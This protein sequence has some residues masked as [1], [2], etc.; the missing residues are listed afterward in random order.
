MPGKTEVVDTSGPQQ[1]RAGL[2]L[3]FIYHVPLLLLLTYVYMAIHG[4]TS[5]RE[6]SNFDF[7]AGGSPI[8]VVIE[9]LYWSAIGVVAKQAFAL[10]RALTAGRFSFMRGLVEGL[11]NLLSVPVIAVAIVYFL[12]ITKLSISTLDLTL[13]KAD[14]KLI[15]ALSIFLGFFGED[16][17]RFLASIGER[18]MG[19]TPK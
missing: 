17:R 7:L 19:V 18:L 6:M 13:E 12:R 14:I 3:I 16:A 1:F 8:G 10:G 2:L 9:V 15:I 11:V 4:I 5:V